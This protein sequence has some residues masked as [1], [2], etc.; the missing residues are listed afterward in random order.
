MHA[1]THTYTYHF[2]PSYNII[3]IQFLYGINIKILGSWSRSGPAPNYCAPSHPF[4]IHPTPP[5]VWIRGWNWLVI[6]QNVWIK[7]DV[8]IA[9]LRLVGKSQTLKNSWQCK[10][11]L[12]VSHL[13]TL[14]VKQADDQ[15]D[16]KR[17]LPSEFFFQ[18]RLSYRF[19]RCE[20]GLY[21]DFIMNF[22]CGRRNVIK[23][24]LDE[25]NLFNKVV[26]EGICY[27]SQRWVLGSGVFL[28]RPSSFL[29]MENSWLE[30]VAFAVWFP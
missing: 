29:L 15:G 12:E 22:G 7:R 8:V 30:V 23:I 16:M 2:A 21:H 13:K 5:S 20:L 17:V 4:N 26:T 18:F 3:S 10:S 25:M 6:F 19:K 9:V 11:K 24:V 14:E 27:V 28:T 1:C